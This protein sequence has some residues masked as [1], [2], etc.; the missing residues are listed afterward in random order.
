MKCRIQMSVA[1]LTFVIFLNSAGTCWVLQLLYTNFQKDLLASIPQ[2]KTSVMLY[3]ISFWGEYIDKS[4]S[5]LYQ[6]PTCCGSA[7]PSSN[8]SYICTHYYLYIYIERGWFVALCY[9]WESAEFDS[10]LGHS[11]FLNSTD[12]SSHVWSWDEI[13]LWQKWLS[14]IFRLDKVVP[15][16]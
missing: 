3:T 16:F 8:Y 2:Y 14:G 13:I 6:N 10:R 4:I 9:R 12:P 15:A 7:W 1:E 11:S 5:W